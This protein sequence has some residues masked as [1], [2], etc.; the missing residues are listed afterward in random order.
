MAGVSS[1][2][3]TLTNPYGGL[4]QNAAN[5]LYGQQLGPL[6]NLLGIGPQAG[7][8][9]AARQ[10]ARLAGATGPLAGLIRDVRGFSGDVIPD[11]LAT[12]QQVSAKGTQAF[13]QLQQQ[14]Q[15][16]L[17]ATTQGLGYAQRFATEAFS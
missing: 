12:G 15:Q 4:S 11:A 1:S 13:E 7:S 8:A 2:G 3:T 5:R 6:L 16:A 17:G 9:K 10:E 14:I